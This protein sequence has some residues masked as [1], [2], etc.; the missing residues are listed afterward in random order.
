MR[1]IS[2]LPSQGWSPGCA[3]WLLFV[4]GFTAYKAHQHLLSGCFTTTLQGRQVNRII[5]EVKRENGIFGEVSKLP[6]G[7]QLLSGE[8]G[9]FLRLGPS[10]PLLLLASQWQPWVHSTASSQLHQSTQLVQQTGITTM[11]CINMQ[12]SINFV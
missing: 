6:R 1:G 10:G 7:S 3:R 2:C 12:F 8:L 5:P 9:L 4:W 11:H